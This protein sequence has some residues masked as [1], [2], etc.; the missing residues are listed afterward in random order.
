MQHEGAIKYL[1][2]EFVQKLTY[3][4]STAI[5]YNRKLFKDDPP[6]YDNNTA[7]ELMEYALLKNAE[8]YQSEEFFA[9]LY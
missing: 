6:P 7:G 8:F 2:K 3:F 9:F 1:H 5:C 4:L